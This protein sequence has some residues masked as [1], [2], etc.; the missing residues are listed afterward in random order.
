RKI[1]A[2]IIGFFEVSI[3]VTALSKVV[4][5]LDNPGN[6]LAYAL[7]YACGNYIGITIENRIALGNLAAQVI[8]KEEN[9][10]ELI[11][12]LRDSGFGVTVLH[13]EGKE[14]SREILQIAIN[15]KDLANL[16]NIVY[17]YDKEAFITT[18]SVNPISGGYFSTIKKK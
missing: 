17:S 1:H 11:K 2:A 7:G 15:R 12:K 10:I 18:N 16:K 9:N 5:N 6:L 4:G 8:L 13:G 3:Y 14:G